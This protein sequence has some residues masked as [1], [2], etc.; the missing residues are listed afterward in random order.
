MH[1]RANRFIHHR[2]FFFRFG[3]TQKTAMQLLRLMAS[4]TVACTNVDLVEF[5]EMYRSDIPSPQTLDIEYDRWMRRWQSETDKPDA[6]QPAL[7]AE[8]RLASCIVEARSNSVCFCSNLTNDSFIDYT[9]CR[10]TGL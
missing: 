3:S 7:H 6:L 5:S 2:N 8:A 4:T 10:S 9:F 1:D